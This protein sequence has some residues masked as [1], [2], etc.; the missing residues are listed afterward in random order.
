ME[1]Q[2]WQAVRDT[3]AAVWFAEC[4]DID[5]SGRALT[6]ARTQPFTEAEFK[7]EVRELPS[8][9]DDIHWGNFGKIGERIVCHDYGRNLLLSLGAQ[10]IE[11]KPISD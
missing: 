9:F 11:M 5:S 2:V 7:S 1:W 6:Q 10:S 3:P 4:F 8:F